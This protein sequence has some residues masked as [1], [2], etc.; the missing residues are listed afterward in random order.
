MHAMFHFR[1]IFTLRLEHE[2]LEDVNVAP[3]DAVHSYKTTIRHTIGLSGSAHL[4]FKNE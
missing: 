1:L 3:D 4:I 2:S